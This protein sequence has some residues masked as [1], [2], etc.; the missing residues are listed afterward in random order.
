MDN[1]VRR[2]WPSTIGHGSNNEK[3]EIWLHQWNASN[4]REF[5]RLFEYVCNHRFELPR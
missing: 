2:P 1:F 5:G 4:A 3:I